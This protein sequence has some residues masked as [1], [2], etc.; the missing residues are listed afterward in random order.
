MVGG[1][2]IYVATL[3]SVAQ[4]SGRFVS[5]ISSSWK[6]LSPFCSTGKLLGTFISNFLLIHSR[7]LYTTLCLGST[8]PSCPLHRHSWVLDDFVFLWRNYLFRSSLLAT[9]HAYTLRWRPHTITAGNLEPVL[10]ARFTLKLFLFWC[11]VLWCYVK[12][13]L[14]CFVVPTIVLL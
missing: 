2:G 7:K 10:R 14:R 5:Y 12:Y 4:Q 3:R 6:C 1:G 9:L 11:H 13:M 8:T